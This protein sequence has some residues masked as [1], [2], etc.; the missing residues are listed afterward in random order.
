MDSFFLSIGFTHYHSDPTV[1]IQHHEGDIL[2][3]ILYVDGIIII[4]SS[5]SM[6]QSVQRALMEQFE[7]TD[8]DFLHFF[9]GLQVIQSLDGISIFQQKYALDMLKQ[10]SM[11]DCKLAPTPFQSGVVF[12]FHLF[13]SF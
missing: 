13:Y 11:L 12:I 1:Y 4:G 5:S 6:I 2:I 9:L 7:M 8:L 10:F 3:L